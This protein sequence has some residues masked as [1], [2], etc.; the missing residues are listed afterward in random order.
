MVASLLWFDPG[1][2]HGQK[3]RPEMGSNQTPTEST[4]FCVRITTRSISRAVYGVR[5][6]RLKPAKFAVH[7]RLIGAGLARETITFFRMVVGFTWRGP[8]NIYGSVCDYDN[9]LYN[10]R[11]T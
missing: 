8:G 3:Y 4:V 2:I 10:F 11:F 7:F 6:V 1:H 9:L 5:L